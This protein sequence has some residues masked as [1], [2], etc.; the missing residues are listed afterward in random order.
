[1]AGPYSSGSSSSAERSMRSVNAIKP[2]IVRERVKPHKVD[3]PLEDAIEDI[4]T[5]AR[6]LIV[7]EPAGCRSLTS[8][9]RQKHDK[10]D[11]GRQSVRPSR[12]GRHLGSTSS[13]NRLPGSSRSAYRCRIEPTRPRRYLYDVK[14]AT[15]S[16][17]ELTP[18]A[19]R[20]MRTSRST[21]RRTGRSRVRYRASQPIR[22]I[23]RGN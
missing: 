3:T 21:A 18:F 10:N 11:R 19:I 16:C 15:L 1:M 22:D 4:L 2:S 5:R 7:A 13:T 12:A 9:S 20:R 6:Q 23:S 14:G 8:C 17:P